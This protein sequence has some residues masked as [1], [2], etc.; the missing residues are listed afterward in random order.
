VPKSE[1]LKVRT[2]QFVATIWDLKNWM[3]HDKPEK[4]HKNLVKLAN[5]YCTKNGGGKE[6]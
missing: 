4:R 5:Q 3:H 2:L 6:F 1:D